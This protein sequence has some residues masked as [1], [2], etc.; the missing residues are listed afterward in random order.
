MGVGGP[1]NSARFTQTGGDVFVNDPGFGLFVGGFGGSGKTGTYTLNTGT[2]TVVATTHVGSDAVG[3][4]NQTGGTHTASRL[5]LGENIGG[6]GTYNMSG[7]TLNV[8]E[9]SYIGDAGKG[10]MNL[11]GNAVVAVTGNTYIGNNGIGPN[12]G[13]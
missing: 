12:A 2:L 10:A 4:F 7:G 5:V 13:T 1:F 6:I 9:N 3:T 8:S 11:T